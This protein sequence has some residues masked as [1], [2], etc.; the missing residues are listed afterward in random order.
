MAASM[1]DK[2]VAWMDIK[3]AGQMDSHLAASRAQTKVAKKV[4]ERVDE[5][6][7]RRAAMKDAKKAVMLAE[8]TVAQSVVWRDVTQAAEKADY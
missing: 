8:T 1:G 6:A 7:Q 2:S 3:R 4:Y 5:M